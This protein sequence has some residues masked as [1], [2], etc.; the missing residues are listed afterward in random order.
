MAATTK[1]HSTRTLDGKLHNHCGIRDFDFY[2]NFL[3][4]R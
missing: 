1:S 4:V 2:F 3:F